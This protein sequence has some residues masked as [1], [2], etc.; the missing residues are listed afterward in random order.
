MRL[1]SLL[2]RTEQAVYLLTEVVS[3]PPRLPLLQAPSS[4]E[5]EGGL[6]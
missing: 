4:F 3:A 2:T 1:V 5:F 6:L